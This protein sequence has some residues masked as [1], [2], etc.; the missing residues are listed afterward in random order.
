MRYTNLILLFAFLF[1]GNLIAQPLGKYGIKG[2]QAPPFEV[3]KW[4]DGNGDDT[5]I[6]LSDYEGKVVYIMNFQSWCPGC[7]SIGFPMLK[8]LKNKFDGNENVV[9]LSIQT[10]FEGQRTNTFS[11]LRKTQKD[12]DLDIP[13]GHDD[14]SNTGNRYS[15]VLDNYKTGGTPWHIIIDKDGKVVFN[16]FE[17]EASE[18]VRLI[19]SSM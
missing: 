19:K 14:G 17:I 5:E 2:E 15:N 11:K 13:F 7:H 18:A 4:I 10:V 12:Y 6:K 9:F 3:S 16:D 1:A 8:Y